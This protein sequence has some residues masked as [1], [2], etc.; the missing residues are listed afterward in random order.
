LWL[1]GPVST[2][3]FFSSGWRIFPIVFKGS[4]AVFNGRRELQS[5]Q[6]WVKVAL[7]TVSKPI[8]L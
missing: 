2:K 8:T 7:I 6:I 5:I 4:S 3:A 1:L